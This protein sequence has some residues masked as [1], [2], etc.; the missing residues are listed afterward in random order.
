MP[1]Q[2]GS[3]PARRGDGGE[4][5]ETERLGG[6]LKRINITAA[7]RPQHSTESERVLDVQALGL[8]ESTRAQCGAGPVHDRAWWRDEAARCG[9]DW[10]GV[11]AGVATA[12]EICQRRA[13]EARRAT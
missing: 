11:M 6:A 3:S 7:G 12:L 1:S 10:A 8:L 4:A 13:S 9:T 5:R 2:N